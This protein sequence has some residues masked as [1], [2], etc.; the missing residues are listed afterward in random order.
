MSPAS[1]RRLNSL[2]TIAMLLGAL[3]IAGGSAASWIAY[4][5]SER[6]LI[7]SV[8]RSNLLIAH[9]L[10]QSLEASPEA[11]L[12]DKMA[13]DLENRW[14][15]LD[16][17]YSGSYVCAVNRQGKLTVNTSRPG[18]VGADVGG[19]L[20]IPEADSDP[21]TVA[22]LVESK[23]D[24]AGY[25][26]SSVGENQIAAF[27]YTPRL[28]WLVA[29]HVP[30]HAVK[31]E[32][33]RAALPWGI[34]LGI[35]AFVLMPL[36]FGAL[37]WAAAVS[38]THAAEARA[39]LE[40]SEGRLRRILNLMPNGVEEI[41]HA[42]RII[43]CNPAFAKM[44]GYEP[45]DLIGQP[46]W[47]ILEEG[48][49]V[50]NIRAFFAD[51]PNV[52]VPAD[53]VVARSRTRDGQCFDIQFD[54][55]LQEEV[56]GQTIGVMAVVTDIS[57]LRESER[58]LR[59]S[60]QQLQ[61]ILDNASAVVSIKDREG[62][63]LLVNR[64]FERVVG[65]TA[66]EALGR[67]NEEIFDK[68]T[69]FH[70]SKND[71]AVLDAGESIEFEETIAKPSGDLSFL[72][73]K[74]PIFD[75]SGHPYA[76]GGISTD[77]TERKAL[78][79]QLRQ[80]QK[81]EAIGRLAGGIAHDFNNLLTAING[82]TEL[83]LI[84]MEK[85]HPLHDDLEE[86]RKAGERASS[87]TNQLLAFSRRQ[88]LQP[89]VVDLNTSVADMDKLLRRLIGENIELVT[90]FD[91]QPC[92]VKADP[93]QLEQVV[94]N[95]AVNARDAMPEGGKLL[96]GTGRLRM[97]TEAAAQAN[98][99]GPG[100]YVLLTVADTGT[101]IHEDLLTQIFEPFYT[102]KAKG[103]GTGLGLSTTYGIVSQSGGGIEVESA[104][105]RGATFKIY[106]PFI[107]DEATVS[108]CQVSSPLLNRGSERVLLVEDEILVR[109]LA[110]RIFTEAGYDV[111]P[112]GSASEALGLSPKA[113]AGLSLIVTDIVLPGMNGRDLASEFVKKCPDLKVIYMSGYTDG[114]FESDGIIG[115]EINF[116]AKPFTA[117]S[118]LLKVRSVLDTES[119]PA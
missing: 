85:S 17:Q 72:S 108:S 5:A 9:Q 20:L 119:T 80:S 14:K 10:A 92:T 23:R 109:N 115:E 78:E 53:P 30:L 48:E 77:I 42:G 76:V 93:G 21:E 59:E 107:D 36:C 56:G 79:S 61:S 25:Y 45:E 28:D 83:A 81:M 34:G 90:L 96:I 24:W 26:V 50:E 89:R 40:S 51:F 60:Q 74:F 105:G 71:K 16:P 41:D 95:L 64:E 69:A 98:L 39:D 103:Q 86:I 87:L 114:A 8:I 100:D 104:A 37:Y 116:L 70:F 47:T 75:A 65:V 84:D 43:Y 31:S 38:Q 112:V 49:T 32:V 55:K 113:I 91:E 4:R 97:S 73:V 101:G 82:Y 54:W 2:K 35:V 99:T 111:L 117:S 15:S 18:S 44:H 94:L 68:E 63:F 27:A 52:H 33:R 106:L 22:E 110:T 57:Q 67:T 88:I 6:V 3:A 7:D 46:C 1:T 12:P 29:V 58:Q 66:E 13:Y 62:Q 19:N 118:L 11:A 102:T